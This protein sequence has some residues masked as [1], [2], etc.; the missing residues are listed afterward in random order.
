MRKSTLLMV[1]ILV[2]IGYSCQQKKQKEV[3]KKQKTAMQAKLD[4]YASFA[5]T[6][7]IAKLSDNEKQLIPILIEVADIMDDIY[8]QE[9]YGDKEA[10]MMM[11]DDE[12]TKKFAEINYGPWDRLRGNE[13]FIQGIGPKPLG[14]QYYPTDMTKEEFEAFNSE[15]KTSLYT[16]V[17]RDKNGNLYT[18][19]YHELFK[20]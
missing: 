11:I 20:E 18:V 15:D 7:D 17:K 16:F 1:T 4:E 12:A 2:F 14:A 6:T 19:P 3:P 9:A 5:L 13:P 10:L 8:W